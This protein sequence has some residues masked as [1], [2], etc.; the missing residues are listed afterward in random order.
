[1]IEITKES[2]LSRIVA[3]NL[4]FFNIGSESRLFMTE[5]NEVPKIYTLSR[6]HNDEVPLRGITLRIG[7]ISEIFNYQQAIFDTLKMIEEGKR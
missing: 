7:N 4:Q 5:S 1:M 6:Y 2:L 3:I